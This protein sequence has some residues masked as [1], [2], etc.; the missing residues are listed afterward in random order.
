MRSDFNT[1]E[2]NHKSMAVN[3]TKPLPQATLD[4]DRAALVGLKTLRNYAP[5][6]ASIAVEAVNALELRL[7]A[8]EEAE[9]LAEQALAAARDARAIAG[10]EL[11]NTMLSVK[12]AVIGQYGHNSDAVQAVGLKKKID[13]RRPARRAPRQG[14]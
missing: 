11:H 12:A 2:V 5:T 14:T 9:I 6:N 1:T 10:W 8:A 3:H 13:Y 7:R 4:S